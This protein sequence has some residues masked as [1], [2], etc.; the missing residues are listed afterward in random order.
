MRLLRWVSKSHAKLATALRGLGHKLAHRACPSCWSRWA[1]GG[2][3]TARPRRAAVIPI[4]TLSSNTS[5]PKQGNAWRLVTRSS[6][7]TQRRRNYLANSRTPAA[8]MDRR[9]SRWRWTR[10]ISRT[11]SS[12]RCSIRGIRH[13]RQQGLCQPRHRRRH[14]TVCRQRP[15]AVADKDRPAAVSG[16][17]HAHGHGGLRRLERAAIAALEDRT[18]TP[19][20]RDRRELPGLPFPTRHQ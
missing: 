12:A 2:M 3:S 7:W 20:R 14:G 9:T 17:T 6:R 5:M 1:I 19:C 11:S 4:A 13:R 16:R 8:T 15:A 10:M 18:A